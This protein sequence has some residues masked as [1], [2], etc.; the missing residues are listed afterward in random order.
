MGTDVQ[1]QTGQVSIGGYAKQT[2]A[3]AFLAPTDVFFPTPGSASVDDD[4]NNVETKAMNGSLD[5]VV[6]SQPGIHTVGGKA[7]TPGYGLQGQGLIKAGIGQDI[8]S[9]ASTVSLGALSGSTYA[10]GSTT[11]TF[12]AAL[13]TPP[14]GIADWCGNI[15][16]LGT[17]ATADYLPI[18]GVSGAVVKTGA[19]LFSHPITDTGSIN[20]QHTL[21]PNTGNNRSL[22][23]L[24]SVVLQYGTMFERRMFDAYVSSLT[25][26]G[27][28]KQTSWDYMFASSQVSSDTASLSTIPQ[29]ASEVNDKPFLEVHGGLYTY[30]AAADT[31]MTVHKRLKAFQWQLKYGMQADS[32]GGGPQ[33]A[34]LQ[35]IGER[36]ESLTWTDLAGQGGN[37]ASIKK[38]FVD[39]GTQVPAALF[40]RNPNTGNAI[41]VYWYNGTISKY[42]PQ[43]PSTKAIAWDGAYTPVPLSGYP[44]VKVVLMNGT[45]TAL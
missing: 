42:T 32:V 43:G 22:L 20:V 16:V 27:D 12:A 25:F 19:S 17:G 35:T 30:M 40:F 15:L 33:G 5:S 4:P 29:S 26:K 28:D 45:T 11:F 31:V 6:A 36:T 37:L 7:S 23:D 13:P 14:A 3:G 44:I 1:T 10:A 24:L 21:L 8:L 9:G 2:V 38:D 18:L 34:E 39:T 41:C